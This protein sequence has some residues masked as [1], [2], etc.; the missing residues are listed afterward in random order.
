LR[1]NIDLVAGLR[2]AALARFALTQTE[3]PEPAQLDFFAAMQ[4]VDDALEYR[5]DDDLG[6]L[7]GQIRNAR[8]FFDELG[9][10]HAAAVHGAPLW[11]LARLKP[12]PTCRGWLG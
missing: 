4:R 6:V 9:L 12:R 7:F 1:R 10:R 11:R 2:V 3:A 8:H 5:I